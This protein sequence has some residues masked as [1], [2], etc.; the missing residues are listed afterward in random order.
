MLA[1]KWI[2]TTQATTRLNIWFNKTLHLVRGVNIEMLEKILNSI[3]DEWVSMEY[4]E[5]NLPT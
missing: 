4:C 5:Y 1:E 2:T 3:A